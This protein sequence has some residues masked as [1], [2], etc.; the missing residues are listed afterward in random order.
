MSVMTL[1]V[2]F[3]AGA[4]GTRGTTSTGRSAV[5]QALRA[6]DPVGARAVEHETAWRSNYLQHFRRLVEAGLGSPEDWRAIATAGLAALDDRMVA[7]DE[8]GDEAPV[9]SLLDAPPRA[10]L[11]TVEIVGQA[12]PAT[13]LILPY[14][15]RELRGQALRDQLQLWARV[16]VLEPSAAAAVEEVI[17]HPQ[18]LRLAG[19]TVAVLGAGAEMGPMAALLGW[20][21]RVAAVS[22]WLSRLNRR[23][24]AGVPAA[25]QAEGG[26]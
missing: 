10:A 7:V 4:D 22:Q 25:R 21:A 11:A 14:R 23:A 13:E 6:V 24:Q 15:G 8:A 9:A 18:W 26:T 3:A 1:G 5:A 17:D 16:G 20:G 12:E 19:H 2:E